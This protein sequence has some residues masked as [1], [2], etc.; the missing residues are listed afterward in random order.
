MEKKMSPS[1]SVAYLVSVKSKTSN[2]KGEVYVI[3]ASSLNT[4]IESH[5][6]PDVVLLIDTIE[7]FG[8][9]F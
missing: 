2:D 5:L 4:F 3:S 6:T 8:L 9:T 1:P 7:T